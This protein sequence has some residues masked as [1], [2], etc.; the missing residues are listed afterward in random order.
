MTPELKNRLARQC[1]IGT[2]NGMLLR[3]RWESGFSVVVNNWDAAAAI[4][5]TKISALTLRQYWYKANLRKEYLEN[6]YT[7]RS[8]EG[9]I[10]PCFFEMERPA[11]RGAPVLPDTIAKKQSAARLKVEKAAARL[12]KAQAELELLNARPD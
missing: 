6:G 12:A 2:D 3:L 1:S 5:G 9:P 8:P 10:E 11:R 7:C 4:L